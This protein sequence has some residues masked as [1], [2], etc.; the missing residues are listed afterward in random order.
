MRAV[1][2]ATL[3]SCFANR[4]SCVPSDLQTDCFSSLR[5]AASED[6]A[7]NKKQDHV[8]Q[9]I[10]SAAGAPAATA[11][12]GTRSATILLI[13]YKVHKVIV[14]HFRFPCLC[15]LDKQFSLPP[16]ICHAS[17]PKFYLIAITHAILSLK[18]PNS[19]LA[20]AN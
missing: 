9:N 11:R 19:I 8:N 2:N 15:E 13:S 10:A 17:V 3:S 4:P 18:Y 14:I 1:L 5:T 16:H 12:T 7:Q 6:I 20:Y